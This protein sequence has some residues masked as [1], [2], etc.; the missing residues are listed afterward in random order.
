MADDAYTVM[1][2][3]GRGCEGQALAETT[4]SVLVADVSFNRRRIGSDHTGYKSAK[5]DGLRMSLLWRYAAS[6]AN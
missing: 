3:V 2:V 6:A 1:D 5:P 4:N